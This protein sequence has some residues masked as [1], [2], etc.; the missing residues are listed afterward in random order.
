MF[1]G[2]EKRERVRRPGR[3]RQTKRSGDREGK[4]SMDLGH[5]GNN[6]SQATHELM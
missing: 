5:I 4:G 1:K 6:F 3:K 2:L